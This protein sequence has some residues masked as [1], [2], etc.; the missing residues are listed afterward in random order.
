[1]DKYTLAYQIW[2]LL[3]AYYTLSVMILILGNNQSERFS[4]FYQDLQQKAD[5]SFD[6]TGYE[7]LLFTFT[8]NRSEPVSAR[9]LAQGRLIADYEAVYINNYINTIELASA[10]AIVAERLRVPYANR[11]FS[12]P[13][14]FSK[15]TE[16]ARLAASDVIIPE[17]I[18]GSKT[19]IMHPSTAELLNE[20]PYILKRADADRGVDNFMVSSYKM[21]M[22]LLADKAPRSLWV[23][24]KFIPND[25]YFRIAY[26]GGE[27]SYAIFRSLQ[28]RPDGNE[29]KAHMY[30]PKGG[31]NA[32]LVPL[33]NVPEPVMR[34]SNQAVLSMDRQFAGVD[35]LYSAVT[36]EACIVEV[37]YN[38]Q[39][40][41][42]ESFSDIRQ[43]AFLNGLKQIKTGQNNANML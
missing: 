14:S 18:A 24:Q 17:T 23:V 19:A 43:Q 35:C 21:I 8:N 32:D 3:C 38:P 11:E 34:L 10:T 40:V 36:D 25:G 2:T 12:K 4:K 26:N 42:I 41:T 13:P 31:I 9:N 29:L 39:L 28:Q 15:L 22:E 1:M 16:Y 7:S 30:R 33:E 6:Y 5:F 37:N 27:A 20:Y